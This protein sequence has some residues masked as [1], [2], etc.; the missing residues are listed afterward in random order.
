M[1]SLRDFTNRG[2]IRY[3]YFVPTELFYSVLRDCIIL[4]RTYMSYMFEKQL[5][6]R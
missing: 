5:K 3:R 2:V 6:H 1:S 4:K